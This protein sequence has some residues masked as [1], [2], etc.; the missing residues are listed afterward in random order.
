MTNILAGA[1]NVRSMI[2]FP[3]QS[4]GKNL[5]DTNFKG[6]I[7]FNDLTFSYD[8]NDVLKNINLVLKPNTITALIGPSGSGK[9][10]IAYLLG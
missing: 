2:E 10:T 1:N 4:W 9:T 7:T 8:K 6:D 5:K 3:I